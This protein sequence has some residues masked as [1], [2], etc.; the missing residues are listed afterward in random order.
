[1]NA[2]NADIFILIL[3]YPCNGFTVI[4]KD[5]ATFDLF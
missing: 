5:L 4:V 2:E 1:M 3:S